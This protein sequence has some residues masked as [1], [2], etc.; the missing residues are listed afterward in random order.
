MSSNTDASSLRGE[1]HRNQDPKD[2]SSIF[3]DCCEIGRGVGGLQLR[4][5]SRPRA[6][7][8]GHLPTEVIYPAEAWA[9]RCVTRA[10]AG[11]TRPRARHRWVV[12]FK[13]PSKTS[14]GTPRDSLPRARGS[15]PRSATAPGTGLGFS[16]PERR[17][18]RQR[19]DAHPP[20]KKEWQGQ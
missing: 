7:R 10:P 5:A 14:R 8:R 6:F 18:A 12:S 16:R 17:S 15:R 3:M 4:H 19:I 11:S 13:R 1:P 2:E 9:A 20:P